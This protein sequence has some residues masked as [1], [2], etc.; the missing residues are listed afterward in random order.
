MRNKPF[1]KAINNKISTLKFPN[2]LFGNSQ[3][4]P[5]LLSK[6]N[7]PMRKMTHWSKQ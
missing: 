3:T 7:K 2:N 6:I 4:I 5:L 1:T